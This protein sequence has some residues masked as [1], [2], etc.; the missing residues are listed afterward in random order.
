MKYFQGLI[1]LLS[2]DNLFHLLDF[3]ALY[4]TLLKILIDVL[5]LTLHDNHAINFKKEVI[6]NRFCSRLS[7]C[8][9]LSEER[10]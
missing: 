4:S 2:K 5:V 1:N 7:L 6:I 3:P 9:G 10:T 8:L